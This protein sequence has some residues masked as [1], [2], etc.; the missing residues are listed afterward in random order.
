[1]PLYG[2]TRSI[3]NSLRR[4]IPVALF[5]LLCFAP[6]LSAQKHE[7][8]DQYRLR[9]DG[10]WFYSTPSG[11]IQ[12]KGDTVPVDFQK[13]L[14]FNS[15]STFGT[16]LDWKFTRKN[17]FYLDF[18]RFNSSNQKILARTITFQGQTFEVGLQTQSQLDA[19]FIS[20]GYQYD[21]I[22]RKRGHIGLG[23][24]FNMF[25]TSAK[26]SAAAQVTGDG[27]QS[28]AR[29]ASGSFWAPIPVAGPQYRL[30]L[31]NSP[32]LFVE[33]DVYGMYFFGY[34]NY[35]S[36]EDSIGYSVGKHVSLKAGYA[37]ASRL[38]VNAQ[39]NRIGIHMT[40]KGATAGLEFSF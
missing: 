2:K 11:T 19:L 34:G 1:M 6:A 27:T 12:G 3:A 10:G 14:G 32:R 39:T 37:L 5:L 29:S 35:V 24:H 20:P 4:A 30:Y 21:I 22:R 31:T 16:G 15:Y 23:I 40:Q 25:D 7:D 13:D 36:L 18:S 33:G 38:I 26:I 28:A 8:F 9:L 17:H